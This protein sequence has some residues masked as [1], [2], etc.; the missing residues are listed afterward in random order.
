MTDE[1][2]LSLMREG[3][4]RGLI[5]AIDKYQRL[6][7]SIAAGML[8][9]KEDREE[10]AADTFYKVWKT[11]D[12]IDTGKGSLKTYICMV[13][14]GLTINKLRQVSVTEELPERERD[15]GF[16]VDFSTEQ[17]A[18]HNRQV[19]A[20][21]IRELPSPE[22]E[23]FICRFYYSLTVPEISRRLSI[24][25]KRVEH[26]IDKTRRALRNALLKGGI[27]L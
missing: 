23:I 13:G 21:C 3:D 25:E 10:V 26:L 18:E 19:I 2:I 5:A 20:R 6:V 17:A 14:R 8:S 1:K 4:E 15:I 24:N 9:S 22:R 16:E 11:A 7:L 27:L 12:R